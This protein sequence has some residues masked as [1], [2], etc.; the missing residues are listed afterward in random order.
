MG[1]GC[2]CSDDRWGI[3]LTQICFVWGT[4]LKCLHKCHLRVSFA[5]READPRSWPMG[6]QVETSP[7]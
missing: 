4:I 5:D 7:T 6:R 2:S 1:L 3:W